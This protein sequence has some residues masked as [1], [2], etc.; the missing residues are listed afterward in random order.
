MD[1]SS[2]G[3]LDEKDTSY[4]DSQPYAKAQADFQRKIVELH[5]RQAAPK[6][7]LAACDHLRDSV[8]WEVGIYLEDREGEA[9]L[10]R[11]LSAALKSDR[12][13]REEA[14]AAKAAAQEKAKQDREKAEQA[15]LEQGKLSHLEMFKQSDEFT[16]W[17]ADGMPTKDEDGNEIAKSRTKK[18][19]RDWDRQKKL[20][21][22]YLSSTS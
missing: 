21:E 11:P 8:L 12:A 6:E 9:A 10:V 17:D 4:P 1:L 22:A 19:K 7:Y 15:K 2:L 16:E 18:L 20:H 3:K 5:N 14:K 13:A